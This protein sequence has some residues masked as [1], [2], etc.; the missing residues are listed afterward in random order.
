MA[1]EEKDIWVFAEHRK[2]ELLDVS[3][4]LLG[5]GQGLAQK[6]GGEVAAIL[7]GHSVEALAQT[8]ASYGAKKVYLVEDERLEEYECDAYVQVLAGLI[9]RYRPRILLAGSTWKACDFLPYVAAKMGM[10][11]AANYTRLTTG[12]EGVLQ[13]IRPIY[14]GR[15]DGVY[16]IAPHRACSLAVMARPGAIGMGKAEEDGEAKLIR[17][18]ARLNPQSIRTKVVEFIKGDPKKMDISQAE[19]IVAAG[20]GIGSAEKLACVEALADA[21][22]ACIAGTRPAVDAGWVSFERQV[23]QTGKSVSPKLYIACGISGA[24]QH[25][26]GMKDSEHIVAINE[27]PEAPIFKICDMGIVGDVQEVVPKLVAD[28]RRVTRSGSPDVEKTI[29]HL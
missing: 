6:L 24:I 27:D 25:T 29:T 19:I 15:L 23:G 13:L 14:G 2:G 5:E 26:A 22:G 12:E 17:V 3:L 8:A 4:E 20:R 18:D 7:L 11:F 1:Q 21:L 9:G 10:A 16:S 28:L